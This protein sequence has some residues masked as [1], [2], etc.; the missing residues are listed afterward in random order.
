MSSAH[1][2][3]QPAYGID[4]A[5]LCSSANCVYSYSTTGANLQHF[6]PIEDFARCG[7]LSTATL[8]YVKSKGW[9]R[10]PICG[11]TLPIVTSTEVPAE[12]PGER[13]PSLFYFYLHTPD[14]DLLP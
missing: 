8:A 3:D 14:G 12:M 13:S 9:C 10:C 6:D 2:F 11:Y 4:P 7:Q 1:E 5:T